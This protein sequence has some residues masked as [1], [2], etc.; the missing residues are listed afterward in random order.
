MPHCAAGTTVELAR[1]NGRS[2]DARV[3]AQSGLSVAIRK[4]SENAW[5]GVGSTIQ[6]NVTNNSWYQVTFTTGDAKLLRG[7]TQ[8]GEYPFRVTIE[9][10]GYSADPLNAA[11][12][13]QHKSRC[14][15]QLVRKKLLAEPS[16]WSNLTS[17]NVYHFSSHDAYVQFPVR[18]NGPICM[19]GKLN[20]C[21]EYPGNA[22]CANFL[23]ERPESTSVGW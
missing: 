13:S 7:D 3:A 8:F 2:M 20:F 5:G 12:R 18:I 22:S 14:I 16:G 10:T 23:L 11:I 4:M 1:N 19:L 6:S 21:T 15:V 9:S 17:Y